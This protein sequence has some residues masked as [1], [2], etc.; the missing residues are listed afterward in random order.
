Y[1]PARAPWLPDLKAELLASPTMFSALAMRPGG[2]AATS[3]A[4]RPMLQLARKV[5]DDSIIARPWRE[6]SNEVARIGKR[7]TTKKTR[8]PASR[9]AA[10]ARRA[11][12]RPLHRQ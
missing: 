9:P 12:K 8:P 5:F 2:T 3:A 7:C 11:A 1:V 4:A 10:R 6:A